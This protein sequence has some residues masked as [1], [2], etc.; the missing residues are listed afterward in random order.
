MAVSQWLDKPASWNR[1]RSVTGSRLV[2]CDGDIPTTAPLDWS[3]A[4]AP[5]AKVT[6]RSGIAASSRVNPSWK[7]RPMPRAIKV[8]LLVVASSILNIG[9]SVSAFAQDAAGQDNI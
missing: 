9:L 5:A 4:S 3:T 6:T 8:S 7:E 2:G 1:A